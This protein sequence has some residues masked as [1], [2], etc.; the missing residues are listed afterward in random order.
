MVMTLGTENLKR[1]DAMLR[2]ARAGMTLQVI[3]DRFGVSRERVRQIVQGA[4]CNA[5]E[6]G[7]FLL[8]G[9]RRGIKK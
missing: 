3:G 5:R 8:S 7:A 1:R 4:G 6:R 9:N 2:M